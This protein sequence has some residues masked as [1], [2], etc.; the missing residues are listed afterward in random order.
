MLEYSPRPG[1]RFAAGAASQLLLLAFLAATSMAHATQETASRAVAVF[2]GGCFWCVE[3]DFDRVKGVVSTVSGY[4]GG[5][6][7]NPTYKQVVSG[8]TGHREAVQIVFD[9]EVVSYGELVEIFWRTVDPTDG[10]GQFCDR[11]HSYTTAIYALDDAQADI[12][13]RSRK[14][15]MEAGMLPGEVATPIESAAPFF[16]AEDYHQDYYEKNPLR[17]KFYRANCGRNDR[18]ETVWGEQAYRGLGAH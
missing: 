11:G 17:Y 16:P 14:A 6:V 7:P 2:A 15:L 4:T 5:R 18:V 10:G 3:S 1:R 13:T 8:K 12:A 9:P